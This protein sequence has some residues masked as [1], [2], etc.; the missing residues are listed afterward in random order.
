MEVVPLDGALGCEVRGVDV[1]KPLDDVQA[2]A[3]KNAF[4]EHGVMLLRGQKVDEAA[5]VRFSRYIGDEESYASTLS[6]YAPQGWPQ[7]Q[8]LSNM[9]KGG[10][11]VGVKGAGQYWHTD[12]SYVRAPAWATVL[13]ALVVPHDDTGTPLGDT[14]FSDCVAALAALPD[15]LRRTLSTLSAW[16]EYVFRFS[17]R[18]DSLPGLAHPVV[19]RHPLTGKEILYVNAGFTHRIVELPEDEGRAL[20]ET[21]YAHVA[22]PR[23]TYRHSWKVGDLLVWDNYSTQHLATGDYGPDQSRLM[24]RTVV[25]GFP[26]H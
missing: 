22:D 21:L 15:E 11:A 18:N 16:H 9:E 25:K 5:F 24:W 7:I 2:A 23:F 17:A 10:K 8:V 20:L 4:L 3:L 26:V 1:S 19:I 14:V 13:H 6:A 12:R